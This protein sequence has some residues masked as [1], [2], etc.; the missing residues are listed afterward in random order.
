MKYT[1]NQLKTQKMLLEIKL[2]DKGLT[3]DEVLYYNKIKLLVSLPI[4][5]KGGGMPSQQG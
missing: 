2:N 3:S 5:T 1:P 4:G